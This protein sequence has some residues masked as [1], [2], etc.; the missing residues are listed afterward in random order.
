[1]RFYWFPLS[2]VLSP[3]VPRGERMGSLMQHCNQRAAGSG[4][5]ALSFPIEHP[6]PA[7]PEH[8]R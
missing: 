7:V 2:S 5:I 6:R 1:V 8:S 4:G 3:L